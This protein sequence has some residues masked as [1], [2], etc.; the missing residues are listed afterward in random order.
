MSNGE[1]AAPTHA[2]RNILIYSDGTGQRGGLYFD[3]ARTNIYKLFR[4]TRVAP[5]SAINPDKQM[6]FYDPGLGSLPEGGTTLQ[7]IFRKLYNFISQA[8]GLGITQNII[9]CY[10]AL[11]RLWQ[12]GD[13]IFVFGFSRGA[14][15]VR[16][17]ASVICMCG[18]PTTDRD[19]KPLRR[20]VGSSVKIATRA[21]KSMYQH[22]SSPRD[23]KYVEQR[24]ALAAAFRNDYRSN[25]PTNAKN[26]NAPPYFV[27]VFDTV[28]SLSNTGSLIILCLAYLVLHVAIAAVLA[29]TFLPFQFWYWFGW[30][31]VGTIC[32]IAAAYVYTHLKFAWR[33]PGY[34]FWDIIHLTTFRQKFYDQNLS[35]L[36]K[37]ARHAI[38]IDERRNDFKR[39]PWGSAHAQFAQET[40]KIEPFEQLWFAGNHADIGGGYAENESRLS[41]V[42]LGWMI[43]EAAHAKLG[44][45][46]L[47]LDQAV[48]QVNGRIDGMQHDETRS[49]VFRFVK[50]TM[51][52]PVEDATLHPSVPRR[53]A[54]PGGVQQ[55]DMSALYRPEALRNHDMVAHFYANIPAPHTTCWQRITSVYGPIIKAIGKFLDEWCGDV[56]SY[57][58]PTNWKAEK[59]MNPER[60]QFTPDSLIS[61]LGLAAGIFF[62][63]AA[64]WIFL[65]WQIVPWLREDIWHSYPLV[66]YFAP[67]TSWVGLALILNWILALPV[68]LIL[69]LLGIILFWAFGQLSTK[70]YQWAS[71]RA[72]KVVTP[73]QT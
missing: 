69:S 16:C 50:K 8:T 36:V 53:F 68:T 7:R 21:V 15:T 55:Y 52:D 25:D 46:R 42:A 59:A 47:I 3:E 27:G 34:F 64:N 35:P 73:A 60:K 66:T 13:R 38:S 63:G 20:D 6:A 44:D 37:Y 70:M 43:E 2:P 23:E 28:A 1:G 39:V 65:F 33:L 11:I 45:E 18:I 67:S 30:I 5:D 48:L 57:L 26:P 71:K 29:R 41:D 22:V 32:A 72:G 54:L 19:G 17:L 49:S 51:R 61:C 58:Y 12:P 24:A 62:V 14:Y 4:A 31:A 9:D 40:Y 10:A 56:A